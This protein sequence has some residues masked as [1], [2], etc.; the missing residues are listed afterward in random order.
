VCRAER[1]ENV[2]DLGCDHDLVELVALVRLY[3]VNVAEGE[4]SEVDVEVEV[5]VTR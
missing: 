4:T 1:G 2:T 5:G 3:P